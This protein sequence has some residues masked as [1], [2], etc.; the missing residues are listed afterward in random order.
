[1]AG[2]LVSGVCGLLLTGRSFHRVRVASRDTLI[3]TNLYLFVNKFVLTIS[4]ISMR[5]RTNT[6]GGC[7]QWVLEAALGIWV[8][9]RVEQPVLFRLPLGDRGEED[10]PHRVPIRAYTVRFL[11]ACLTADT[12]AQPTIQ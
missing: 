11:F 12:P 1:M 9:T 2:L 4:C 6:A 10:Q 8:D 7:T 5:F 3:L